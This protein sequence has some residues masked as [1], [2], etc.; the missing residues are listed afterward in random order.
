MQKI[1]ILNKNSIKK[2]RKKREKKMK[3]YLSNSPEMNF[4]TFSCAT[5]SVN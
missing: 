4:S 1:I 2:E 5:S 3:N